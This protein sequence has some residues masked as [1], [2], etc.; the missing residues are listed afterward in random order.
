MMAQNEDGTSVPAVELHSIADR[1]EIA[2]GVMMPRLGIGTSH[3][4]GATNVEAEVAAALELGYRLIDT[5]TAYMNEGEI[6]TALERAGV[7]REELFVTTKVWPS[8]QGYEQTL[9]TFHRSRSRL[10]LDYLD[11]FL[12][13]WPEPRLTA[14]TW[15]ALEELHASGAVR[16]IGVSNFM[17]SDFEQLFETATVSP[18]INQIEFH[19]YFQRPELVAYCMSHGVTVQ[20]WSPLIQGRVSKIPVLV[21]IGN[22]HGKTAAQV[23][24]RWMLQRGITTIPK[25]SHRERLQENADVFDFAL[26]PQ[27]MAAID[28]LD[29]NES[30]S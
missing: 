16:A 6:G 10:R 9:R 21:E 23:T 29:R 25:S 4:V 8:D 22:R 5:A 12:I 13:H 2:P 27:E 1:V 24:I 17:E 7:A 14:E 30:E 18:A 28:A 3:V 15:R 26:T 11:L 20:A 19:P